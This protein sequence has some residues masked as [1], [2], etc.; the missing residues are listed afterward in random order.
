VAWGRFAAPGFFEGDEAAGEIARLSPWNQET[1]S[2]LWN[3]RVPDC[4]TC[5]NSDLL[6]EAVMARLLHFLH[7]LLL[8]SCMAA[9]AIGVVIAAASIFG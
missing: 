4:G 7:E 3:L 1:S 2:K 8:F 5:G 9:F 6:R